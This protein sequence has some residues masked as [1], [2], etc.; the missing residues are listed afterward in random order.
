MNSNRCVKLQFV[1]YILYLYLLTDIKY[2]HVVYT[3]ILHIHIY[4]SIKVHNFLY[5]M[6]DADL[7]LAYIIYNYAN[8]LC[9]TSYSCSIRKFVLY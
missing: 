9:C 1:Y 3:S 7:N 8:L 4:S 5:H 6:N 2:I